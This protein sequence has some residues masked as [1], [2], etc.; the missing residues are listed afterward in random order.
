[1]TTLAAGQWA[2]WKPDTRRRLRSDSDLGQTG[3]GEKES[4]YVFKVELSS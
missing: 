3:C 4:E 1:M 2:G